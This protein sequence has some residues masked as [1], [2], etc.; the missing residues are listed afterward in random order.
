MQCVCSYCCIYS[1]CPWYKITYLYSLSNSASNK[2]NTRPQPSTT[3]ALI[4]YS[5]SNF[6]PHVPINVNYYIHT[7]K[8]ISMYKMRVFSPPRIH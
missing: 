3:D 5:S 7:S 2:L 1:M 4:N 6:F 8:N